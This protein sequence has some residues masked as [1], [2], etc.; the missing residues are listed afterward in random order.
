MTNR[1]MQVEVRTHFSGAWARGFEVV[2]TIRDPRR[3]GDTRVR[4]RRLADGAV[5]PKDFAERDVRPVR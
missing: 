1:G 3:D 2:E 4:V 5:L